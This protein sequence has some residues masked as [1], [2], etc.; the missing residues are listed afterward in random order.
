MGHLIL[1]IKTL[2]DVAALVAG[3]Y[4]YS[5]VDKNGDLILSSN[6]IIAQ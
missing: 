2:I 6:F 3:T 4:M 1:T 5:I